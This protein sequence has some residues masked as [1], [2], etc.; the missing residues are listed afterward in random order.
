MSIENLDPVV[1][2]IVD[3]VGERVMDT[4]EGLNVTLSFE[5]SLEVSRELGYI[6]ANKGRVGGFSPTDE[7]LT[8][9]GVDKAAY[10]ADKEAQKEL[11]ALESRIA[12]LQK[13]RDELL[14]G[15]P[16]TPVVTTAPNTEGVEAIQA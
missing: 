6:K 8:F 2:K 7:G 9:A 13:K 15:T 5:T 1:E 12:S 4:F 11:T 3:L 16:E 14:N 10:M